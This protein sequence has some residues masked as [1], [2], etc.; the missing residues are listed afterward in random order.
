MIRAKKAR[1]EIEEGLV[2][3]LAEQEKVK[4]IEENI[5]KAIAHTAYN[6]RNYLELL[7]YYRDF[8]S[9]FGNTPEKEAFAAYLTPELMQKTA[10]ILISLNPPQPQP[11]KFIGYPVL[12]EMFFKTGKELELTQYVKNLE[13]NYP[14]GN[15]E[16]ASLM[17]SLIT[18]YTDIRFYPAQEL[19]QIA[20]IDTKNHQ[21]ALL[22]AL[23]A[24][25]KDAIDKIKDQFIN[26][27]DL[28][29]CLFL[30]EGI[31]QFRGSLSPEIKRNLGASLI[32]RIDALLAS[33]QLPTD[34]DN[35]LI[36]P[37]AK[38]ILEK[39][40]QD[41]KKG[42]ILKHAALCALAGVA[43]KLTQE[44]TKDFLLRLNNSMQTICAFD[45][46][47]LSQFAKESTMEATKEILNKLDG[48]IAYVIK[49]GDFKLDLSSEEKEL[50]IRDALKNRTGNAPYLF[51]QNEA[52]DFFYHTANQTRLLDEQQ[53]Q[54]LNLTATQIVVS[55]E[56]FQRLQGTFPA[57]ER[58]HIFEPALE[59]EIGKIFDNCLS[60]SLDCYNYLKKD[61]S[62]SNFQKELAAQMAVGKV[63]ETLR[64][65]VTNEG[66]AQYLK[67]ENIL[68]KSEIEKNLQLIAYADYLSNTVK[69]SLNEIMVLANE[70]N[71]LKGR[72]DSL[73][74]KGKL[75]EAKQLEGLISTIT[76]IQ[77]GMFNHYVTYL[78]YN[79]ETENEINNLQYFKDK[80]H[81]ND[82]LKEILDASRAVLTD[83]ARL[84]ETKTDVLKA[85]ARTA[86]ALLEPSDNENKKELQAIGQ[87]FK[88]TPSLN[89]LGKAILVLLSTL[90]AGVGLFVTGGIVANQTYKDS[91]LFKA[92]YKD[93]FKPESE[94]EED[95]RQEGF[96]NQ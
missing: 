30:I 68:A 41:D 91:R 28:E 88:F 65:T 7:R 71:N 34:F 47:E 85:M 27:K 92:L 87:K 46:G 60:S 48:T 54:L 80:Q 53:K 5:S 81:Q 94:S 76:K 77:H 8:K 12:K 4:I 90:A 21:L 14:D 72:Q 3:D 17:I 52:G 55:L 78:E 56:P 6:P 37:K 96:S 66:L 89:L 57:Q 51:I 13:R 93:T 45:D 38:N 2:P 50:K 43:E 79:E 42:A 24:K 95:K 33:K 23:A 36:D 82:N 19:P 86:Q 44:E 9:E 83:V 63:L 59:S 73:V 35:Y 49:I 64:K 11:W 61:I 40:N 18:G 10:E 1:K 20:N 32:D 74:K 62:P 58:D 67:E 22:L 75:D 69:P 39:L 29:S 26:N 70:L 15:H 16:I 25:D 31:K 84:P